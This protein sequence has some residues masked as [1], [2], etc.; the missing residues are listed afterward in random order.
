MDQG[1][2]Q[3][4]ISRDLYKFDRTQC[5]WDMTTTACATHNPERVDDT[6]VAVTQAYMQNMQDTAAMKRS[7]T[8][9]ASRSC[10]L[11]KT[12]SSF[13]CPRTCAT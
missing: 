2:T 7:E 8:N 4:V 10:S 1:G 6:T 13:R 9:Q 5:K 12:R 11:A 3:K